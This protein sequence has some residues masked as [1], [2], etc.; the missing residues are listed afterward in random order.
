VKCGCTLLN[1]PARAFNKLERCDAR[2]EHSCEGRVEDRQSFACSCPSDNAVIVYS[3]AVPLTTVISK[4][5]NHQDG[6]LITDLGS[7]E[8]VEECIHYKCGFEGIHRQLLRL[9]LNCPSSTSRRI[10]TN[11][12]S[13]SCQLPDPTPT[14]LSICQRWLLVTKAP[15]ECLVSLVKYLRKSKV[16][17]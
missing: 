2:R 10:T 15:N 9:H 16:S 3:E 12:Q 8:A 13:V 17:Q 5:E 4:H 14:W 6:A 11:S 1:D 7:L